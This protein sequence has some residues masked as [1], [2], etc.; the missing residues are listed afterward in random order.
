MSL[1]KYSNIFGAPNTGVHS[2][3]IFDIAIV[4]LGLTIVLA[5]GLSFYLD[6]N[7]ILTLIV[8]LILGIIMHKIFCV[9]TTL[10]KLIFEKN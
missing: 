2:Y 7:F 5:F 4:D 1:C 8:I 6:T 10:N 3:R 9:N